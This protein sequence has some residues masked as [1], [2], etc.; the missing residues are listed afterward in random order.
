MLKP[1]KSYT[2]NLRLFS[3]AEND[4]I[5][6]VFHSNQPNISLIIST[7]VFLQRNKNPVMAIIAAIKTMEVRTMRNSN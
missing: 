1:R 2:N 7:A 4:I 3:R 6:G 5:H